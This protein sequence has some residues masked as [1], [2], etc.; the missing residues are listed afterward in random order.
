MLT[1]EEV[2]STCYLLGLLVPVGPTSFGYSYQYRYDIK[3]YALHATNWAYMVQ[4][5]NSYQACYEIFTSE[6]LRKINLPI[7][8]AS[9]KDVYRYIT[10]NSIAY[11]F[12]FSGETRT[13]GVAIRLPAVP[14]SDIY[15]LKKTLQK[16]GVYCAVSIAKHDLEI[17]I[18]RNDIQDELRHRVLNICPSN[19][20][21]NF[22]YASK[23]A[24]IL[25]IEDY[26]KF[27]KLSSLFTKDTAIN[28]MYSRCMELSNG[29]D[30][31]KKYDKPMQLLDLIRFLQKEKAVVIGVHT[32]EHFKICKNFGATI[33]SLDPDRSIFGVRLSMD[34]NSKDTRERLK[35]ILTRIGFYG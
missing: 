9:V 13:E 14:I 2:F 12:I 21:G 15:I 7:R 1:P 20:I 19:T 31:V 26:A 27:N 24:F 16:A 30:W 23:V 35:G 17:L 32:P 29:E 5:S 25:A 34:I 22:Q 4:L 3:N 10:F 6:G 28:Y 33:I 11:A 18:T 8:A